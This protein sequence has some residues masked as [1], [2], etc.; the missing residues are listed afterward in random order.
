MDPASALIGTGAIF[1]DLLKKLWIR[2]KRCAG[3]L[4]Q[5]KCLQEDLKEALESFKT[6]SSLLKR[7]GSSLPE[8]I[9]SNLSR[10]MQSIERQLKDLNPIMHN[11]R[12]KF[13]SYDTTRDKAVASCSRFATTT[14]VVEHF[15]TIQNVVRHMQSSSLHITTMLAVLM[16]RR[17]TESQS[18]A[19]AYQ[20]TSEPDP[21]SS[22]S[23][24][25]DIQG[26]SSGNA[27]VSKSSKENKQGDKKK[28]CQN[29][30]TTKSK[31]AHQNCP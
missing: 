28:C 5:Y 14:A 7:Y 3:Q 17:R 11:L 26:S 19:L 23:K 13:C 21:G 16:K 22:R 2:I 8:E 25:K 31:R 27:F 1:Y 15:N 24:P 6:I 30:D 29:K 12:K 4:E 18:T 20:Q 10:E 9:K